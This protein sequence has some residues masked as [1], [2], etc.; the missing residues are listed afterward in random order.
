MS[1]QETLS[2]ITPRTN[3]SFINQNPNRYNVE[4]DYLSGANV[5]RVEI[6]DR[7]VSRKFNQEGGD[8]YNV[9]SVTPQEKKKDRYYTESEIFRE[10]MLTLLHE[11]HHQYC[12]NILLEN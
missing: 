5:I 12:H 1:A 3:V 10:K 2:K 8:R 9:A 6:D 11:H 7:V 4:G